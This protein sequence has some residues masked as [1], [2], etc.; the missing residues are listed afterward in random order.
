MPVYWYDGPYAEP[1]WAITKHA[2]IVQIAKQ[3]KLF[4]NRQRLVILADEQG[5][6]AQ[7]EEPLDMEMMPS[8]SR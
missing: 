5:D 7:E 6:Y 4:T 3:P 8:S 1:F 2:D